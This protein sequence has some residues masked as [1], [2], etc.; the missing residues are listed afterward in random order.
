[1]TAAEVNYLK[2]SSLQDRVH[3]EEGNEERA[4]KY[5]NVI[6][7]EYRRGLKNGADLK[8]AEA[9]LLE[10]RNRSVE[11]KYAF[12]D[13]KIKLEREIGLYIETSPHTEN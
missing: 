7:D 8:N 1:M 10:A 12:I 9:T 6:L 2:L 4:G 11:F 5:Y 13:T 3:V